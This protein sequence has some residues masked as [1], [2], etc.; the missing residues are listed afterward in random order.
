MLSGNVIGIVNVEALPERNHDVARSTEM[1]RF[2][3]LYVR[4][5]S[6]DDAK[7]WKNA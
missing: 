5:H 7:Y 1:S 3:T 4:V 2:G 6:A